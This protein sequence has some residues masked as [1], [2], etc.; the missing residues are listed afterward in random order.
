MK[1]I[2]S[3]LGLTLFI[4]G[5]MLGQYQQNPGK[6]NSTV[7]KTFAIEKNGVE[8]PYNVKVMEHRT[9]PMQWDKQDKG[10]VNQN[11]KYVADKVTKLVAVDT[12]NDKEYEQYFVLRYRKSLADKFEIVATDNGFA[13]QVE[14]KSLKIFEKEGIYFIDNSDQDFFSVDEFGEIG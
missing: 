13:V 4:S 6:L 12:D 11:R 2:V 7:Y 10:K 9:Y 5:P 3:L 8:I 1:N 14:D